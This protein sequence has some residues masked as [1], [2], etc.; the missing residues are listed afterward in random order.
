MIRVK[1]KNF[2][3]RYKADYLFMLPYLIIFL[4]FQ[5]LPVLASVV[6][7]FTYFNVFEPPQFIGLGNYF[8][9]FLNDDL[10]MTAL[11]NTFVLTLITGPVG[12]VLSF[13]VAWMV[14]EFNPKLRSFLT[15]LFYIPALSG[16]LAGIW[17]I[18]F[19]GDQYGILNGVLM[20]LNVIFSPI[21]WLTDTD[22]MMPVCIVIAIWMSL[23]TSFLAFVAGFRT[24]DEK[25]YEAAAIDGIRNRYQELWY[26]TLP[27]MKP[28]LLFGAVMSITSSFSVSAMVSS[29]F[30]F[31]STGYRLYTLVHMLEDYGGQRF[32]MGY[33]SAVA[34][35]LFLMM[36]LINRAVQ[37]L[38]AKVGQ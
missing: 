9:M 8:E 26:I 27:A 15:L 6:L 5:I 21:Q 17:M 2:L 20:D 1:K 23:G 38:I 19:S 33:A 36:L 13:G 30:G 3:L 10:F 12:Y 4:L 32:E 24:V 28:Q 35:I 22:Y 37:K 31:P 25:L 7:G 11:A 14:N 18:V 16:G 34:T 29:V